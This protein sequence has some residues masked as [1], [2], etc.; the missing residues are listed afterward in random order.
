M[1]PVPGRRGPRGD[2]GHPGVRGRRGVPGVQGLQGPIGPAGAPGVPAQA[3]NS[4]EGTSPGLRALWY[5]MGALKELPTEAEFRSKKPVKMTTVPNLNF[6]GQDKEVTFA[7]SGLRTDFAARFEG[8]Q[9]PSFCFVLLRLFFPRDFSTSPKLGSGLLFLKATMV[10]IWLST[11][12]R[13]TPQ[14]PVIIDAP[15][16]CSSLRLLTMMACTA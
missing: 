4:L 2:D 5:S 11:T 14:F 15:P 9:P 8:Y 12:S 6:Q 3:Q 7:N 10:Q 1:S 16:T 13:Y